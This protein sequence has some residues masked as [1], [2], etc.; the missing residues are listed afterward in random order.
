MKAKHFIQGLVFGFGIM[1]CITFDM[2][3]L[4]MLHK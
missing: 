3:A 4:V 2:I 1:T